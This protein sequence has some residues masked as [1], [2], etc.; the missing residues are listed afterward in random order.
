MQFKFINNQRILIKSNNEEIK[1]N[2]ND[3]VEYIGI[4]YKINNNLYD[5]E[6]S[7]KKF[8]GKVETDRGDGTGI[9]GIYIQP[10]FIF[11]QIDN[12]WLKISNYSFPL[13]KTL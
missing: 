4:F 2:D 8:I 10:L 13:H 7:E 3:V 11:D 12:E 6:E 9:T 5:M 1:V